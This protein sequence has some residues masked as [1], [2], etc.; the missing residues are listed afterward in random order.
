VVNDALGALRVKIGHEK[1]WVN[2]HAWEPVW[3]VDFPMFDYDEEERRWTACHHPFTSP[4]DEHLALLGTDPGG[5]LAK[6]YDLALNGS[7]LGWRL[8]ADSPGGRSGTGV[9]G[10][11]HF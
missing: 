10:A 7:E 5:C 9:Q 4:K 6:A 8:G 3:V 11:G 1:G 2:G